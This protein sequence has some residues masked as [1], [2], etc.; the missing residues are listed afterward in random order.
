MPRP[1]LLR[2]LFWLLCAVVALLSLVPTEVLPPSA[3]AWS[4]K[5][6]HALGFAA[7]GAVGLLAYP[8][9]RL[10]LFVGLLAFGGAIEL[11]QATTTWRH[12]EWADWLADGVGLGAAWAI[13]AAAD[14]RRRIANRC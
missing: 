14:F 10:G 4:D 11:A 1:S 3:F 13:S 6:Q 2:P 7:L 5:A 9:R 8:A 12:A